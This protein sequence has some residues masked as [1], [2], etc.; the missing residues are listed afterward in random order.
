MKAGEWHNV[1][2][3]KKKLTW[4]AG[5]L[6]LF[7]I[8]FAGNL[9]S[10]LDL[11]STSRRSSSS[12]C[13]EASEVRTAGTTANRASAATSYV[14]TSDNFPANVRLCP[15]TTENCK[16]IGG[17]L[18]GDAVHPLEG[19]AGESISGN[20][21]WIKFR[22]NG[23]IAYIHSSLLSSSRTSTST[24]YVT[25][26]NNASAAVRSCP[27]RTA[28]CTVIGGLLPGDTVRPQEAVAGESVNGNV[29]WLK[30]RHNGKI[31]YIHSSLVTASR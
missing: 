13:R 9:L 21:N 5:C 22:F 7:L 29:I 14:K 24:Y 23:T 2:A 1:R 27:R 30:F 19:V 3:K 11:D 31:A 16:V 17:L 20:E 18:P 12:T 6:F 28:D 15:R 25:T 26:K 8:L 10:G 4:K